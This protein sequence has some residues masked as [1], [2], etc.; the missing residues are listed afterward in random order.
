MGEVRDIS[1]F[2]LGFKDS[3]RFSASFKESPTEKFSASMGEVQIVETGD[4]NKLKNKPRIEGR[5]LIGDKTYN[6]LGLF[7]VT[8]QDI[9][10]MMFGGH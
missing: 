3:E 8:P 1:E 10:E 9:D 6:Q 5:E 4:Y 7:D 2:T